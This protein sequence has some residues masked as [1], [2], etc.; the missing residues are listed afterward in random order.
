MQIN[1][2]TLLNT[3]PDLSMYEVKPEDKE[4]EAQISVADLK[5]M[6]LAIN[7]S[8]RRIHAL[9]TDIEA[10]EQKIASL[11]RGLYADAHSRK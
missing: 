5:E 10:A 9:L 7:V 1:L 4:T 11:E 3:N 8:S 2:H 6:L